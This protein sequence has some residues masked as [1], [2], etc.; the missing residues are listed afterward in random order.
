MP[1]VLV[2]G[3]VLAVLCVRMHDVL[4]RMLQI[5]RLGEFRMRGAALVTAWR[6][7]KNR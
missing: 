1:S 2:M 3:G 6:G 4:L 5:A 7:C